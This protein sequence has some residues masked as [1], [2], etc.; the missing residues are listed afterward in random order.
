MV[1]FNAHSL[2]RSLLRNKGKE[3]WLKQAEFIQNNIN[4]AT[5]D[6]AFAKMPKEVRGE[7]N[8]E[9]KKTLLRRK[10]NLTK[11]DQ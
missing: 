1:F 6:E 5:I 8:D 11:L 10:D 7:A 4:K 3:E 2:D 9:L